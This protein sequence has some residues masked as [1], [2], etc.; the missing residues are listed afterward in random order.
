MKDPCKK[1]VVRPACT[2]GCEPHDKFQ[3][4]VGELF[5][6]KQRINSISVDIINYLETI[7]TPLLFI[8]SIFDIIFHT[9]KYFLG[10][11]NIVDLKKKRKL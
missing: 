4:H 2:I 10:K 3:E 11:I 6:T 7:L 5:R 9:I 1:C 8:F